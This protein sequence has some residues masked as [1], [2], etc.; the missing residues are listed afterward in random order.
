V[1]SRLTVEVA[2]EFL[3]EIRADAI[4]VPFFDSD[5]P[6]RG[7][8]GRADWRLCGRFS[9]LLLSGKLCGEAGEAAL[10]AAGRGWVAPRVMALG[11]GPRR[12]FDRRDWEALG[13]DVVNR[14]L[15]LGAKVVAFPVSDPDGGRLGIQDRVAGLLS[16]AVAAFAEDSAEL[17]LQ[18][19]APEADATRVQKAAEFA[20]RMSPSPVAL[21]IEAAHDLGPALRPPQGGAAAGRRGAQIFK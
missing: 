3:E 1:S 8:A 19:V 11:L 20:A 21:Q 17:R 12:E 7:A 10:L 4:I 5:R 14:A 9:K 13:R 2:T 18:L 15:R 16:G 6:L